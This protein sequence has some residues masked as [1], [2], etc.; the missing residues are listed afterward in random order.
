MM[1]RRRPEKGC[2]LIRAINE[3]MQLMRLDHCDVRKKLSKKC[4]GGY[5]C[6]DQTG[7]EPCVL[8]SSKSQEASA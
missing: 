1:V 4:A 6:I 3:V 7:K 8:A 5:V 2:F